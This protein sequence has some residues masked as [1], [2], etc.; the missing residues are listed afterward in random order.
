MI[1]M[2]KTKKEHYVPQCYLKNFMIPGTDEKINVF[3]KSK[4]Q[5]RLK[6]NILDNA[7]IRIF[8]N[9]LKTYMGYIY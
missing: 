4:E 2:G 8:S 7:Y 9:I 1:F 5:V 6:Q 3:D